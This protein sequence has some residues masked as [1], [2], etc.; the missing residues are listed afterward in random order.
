MQWAEPAAEFRADVLGARGLPSGASSQVKR[1]NAGV[2]TETVP[3][4]APKSQGQIVI[5]RLCF[6][7]WP[8]MYMCWPGWQPRILVCRIWLR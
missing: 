1:M 6:G 3:R 8:V 7:V 5:H 2:L 4:F